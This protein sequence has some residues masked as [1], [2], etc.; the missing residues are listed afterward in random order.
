[1]KL[2]KEREKQLLKE[3]EKMKEIQ[4]LFTYATIGIGVIFTICLIGYAFF[5]VL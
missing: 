4:D 3:I 2:R 1:M 5:I